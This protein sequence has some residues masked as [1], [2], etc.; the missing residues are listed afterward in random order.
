MKTVYN[1]AQR[2][3]RHSLTLHVRRYVVTAMK[4]VHWL[5]ICL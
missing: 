4:P 3:Y 1:Q 2:E 5:Q